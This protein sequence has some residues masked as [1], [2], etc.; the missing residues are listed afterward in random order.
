VSTTAKKTRKSSRKESMTLKA[1][2]RNKRS[3]SMLK[4]QQVDERC[5][6]DQLSTETT[7]V[8]N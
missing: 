1:T 6:N 2:R 3:K 5:M 8:K 7:C 4:T